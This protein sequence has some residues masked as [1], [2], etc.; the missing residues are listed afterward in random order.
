MDMALGGDKFS[1]KGAGVLDGEEFFED[2]QY[3]EEDQGKAC[4]GVTAEDID[5]GYGG[6]EYEHE[7]AGG[8]TEA[9]EGMAGIEVTAAGQSDAQLAGAG[10]A[11]EFKLT[12]GTDELVPNKFAGAARAQMGAFGKVLG[13]RS[14]GQGSEEGLYFFSFAAGQV[15]KLVGGAGVVFNDEF[16][17]VP[18]ELS[19]VLVANVGERMA[20]AEA[21]CGG[22]DVKDTAVGEDEEGAFE[23]DDDPAEGELFP[24]G[25]GGTAGGDQ[26][27]LFARFE[28][29]GEKF[30]ATEETG[31]AFFEAAFIDVFVVGEDGVAVDGQAEGGLFG[32]GRRRWCIG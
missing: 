9:E 23:V 5:Q 28:K 10:L 19:A 13:D 17:A 1:D 22:G 18:A 25:H 7:F 3:G 21:G 12:V 30:D 24:E 6:I 11:L 31:L 32:F 26:E 20:I 8:V 27:Y 16:V 14:R 29:R 4:L 15:E 2:E